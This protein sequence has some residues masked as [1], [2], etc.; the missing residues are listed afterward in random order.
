MTITELNKNILILNSKDE[1][2]ELEED[3]LDEQAKKSKKSD[4]DELSAMKS[5]S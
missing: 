2:D 1:D 4:D 3:E 5:V